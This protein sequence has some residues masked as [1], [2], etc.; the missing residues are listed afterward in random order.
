MES[1][2]RD[3]RKG[4]KK[5][6]RARHKLSREMNVECSETATQVII[7]LNNGNRCKSASHSLFIMFQFLA[8]CNAG[9]I[10]GVQGDNLQR[11]IDAT[12][13]VC[14]L[15]TPVG[16]SY[17][18]VKCATEDDAQIIYDKLH[19]KARLEGQNAALYLSFVSRG[20]NHQFVLG[21][22]YFCWSIK[23]LLLSIQQFLKFVSKPREPDCLQDYVWLRISSAR[24]K[25]DFSWT[26]YL[27]VMK[28]CWML[29]FVGKLPSSNVSC[30]FS[31]GT[32]PSELKHRRV[33]HFGFEFK[34]GVN[35]VN[36]DEPI[37]PIPQN[38][39]FLRELFDKHGC[40]QYCYDQLTI[41]NYS[42]GQGA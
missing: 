6:R 11:L 8:I 5:Q 35:S 1:S 28:V 34:Y 4:L 27:G 24:R 23:L 7:Y 37:E 19:G 2:R 10:A 29:S 16:K 3:E 15:I 21:R 18:F 17:S 9:L 31:G 22:F 36:P 39:G 14:E 30:M 38:Y 20:C 32:I 12:S 25:N 33:K 42:P 41:N 13:V 40:G 26:L